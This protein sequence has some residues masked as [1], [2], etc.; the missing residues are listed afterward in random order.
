VDQNYPYVVRGIIQFILLGVFFF[1]EAAPLLDGFTLG[2]KHTTD[3]TV[4][5]AE[6]K[7][8]YHQRAYNCWIAAFF[9]CCL[10]SIFWLSILNSFKKFIIIIKCS[11]ICYISICWCYNRRKW[12]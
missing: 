10:I 1:V 11:N 4:F 3:P 2:G 6:L 5:N 12:L 7:D 9:L 8:A